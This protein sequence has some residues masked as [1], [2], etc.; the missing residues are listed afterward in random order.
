MIN[1]TI[2]S[3]STA[4]GEGAISIIR[5]SGQDAIAIANRF[6]SFNLENKATH[7]I[8][9]GYVEDEGEIIDEVLV[10]LMRAP[11]TYT[12]EDVV[13][14]NSHG[15]YAVT[16]RILEIALK[17]GCRLAKP[18][19]YTKRAFLNGRID[20]SQAE[21]ISDLISAKNNQAAKLA[22]NGLHKGLHYEIKKIREE[23]LT[24]IANL[25]V[26]IDYPEYDDVIFLTNELVKPQIE[27]FSQKIAQL[28]ASSRDGILLT[29]GVKMVLVGKP[30]VGKSSLLNYLLGEEK[31]IV[32]NIAGTTRDVIESNLNIK[33]VHFKIFDTAGIREALDEIEQ[34]GIKKTKYHIENSDLIILVIDNSENL[35]HDELEILEYIKRRNHIVVI[36]K[37]DLKKQWE[38]DFKDHHYV[39]LSIT[40]D[41][42]LEGFYQKISEVL[43]LSQ[44]E[45][46]DQTVVTRV[47]HIEIL[48]RAQVI[49]DDLLKAIHDNYGVDL[50]VIDLHQLWQL[51]GE[52]LGDSLDEGV[53]DRLFS[54]FCLGK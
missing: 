44:I 14:I 43:A 36:N 45:F 12:L 30:N 17:N 23:V 20:L 51:F 2:V 25:E 35:T 54:E 22:I 1:E 39:E 49:I 52:I 3:I 16:N 26:N 29:E 6:L 37:I 5:L 15:G 11:R 27:E 7:T 4:V 24:L 18:G 21:A 8:N 34:L 41:V 10:M 50:L 9:Y 13:E 47:R 53:I 31:A 48:N 28:L 42:N 19:E 38:Y 33:G 40:E 32:S 46:Q